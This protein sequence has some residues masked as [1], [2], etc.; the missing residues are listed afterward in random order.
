[1]PKQIA[2]SSSEYDCSYG[3]FVSDHYHIDPSTGVPDG[4]KAKETIV[5]MRNVNAQNLHES[6]ARL[7][8]V[9]SLVVATTNTLRDPKTS[10]KKAKA[11]MD[12][13]TKS[14]LPSL[15]IVAATSREAAN[16]VSPIACGKYAHASEAAEKRKERKELGRR[17]PKEEVAL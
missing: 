4:S 12:I 1:M 7:S 17:I 2:P 16:I 5:G 9:K 8:D 3:Q 6:A 14:I 13:V 15:D 10:A 11:A